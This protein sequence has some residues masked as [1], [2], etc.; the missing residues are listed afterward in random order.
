MAPVSTKPFF[1]GADGGIGFHVQLQN[2]NYK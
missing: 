1:L 2:D